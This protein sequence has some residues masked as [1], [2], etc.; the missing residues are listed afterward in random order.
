MEPIIAVGRVA[1]QWQHLGLSKRG[2]N[3]THLRLTRFYLY[4]HHLTLE[5]ARITA[6]FPMAYADA[7]AMT[8]AIREDA[9]VVTGDPEFRAVAHLVDIL[10]I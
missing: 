6:D 7:F 5:A 4:N 3:S 8:T 10:W 2:S 9:T 1:A